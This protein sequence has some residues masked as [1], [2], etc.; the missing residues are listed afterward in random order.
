LQHRNQPN[1]SLRPLNIGQHMPPVAE[2]IPL[3]VNNDH[4]P[5]LSSDNDSNDDEFDDYYTAPVVGAERAID[6]SQNTWSFDGYGT[7]L[8]EMCWSQWIDR[9][10]RLKPRFFSM[11]PNGG[12]LQHVDHLLPMV[13]PKSMTLEAQKSEEDSSPW[14]TPSEREFTDI[15]VENGETQQA[16]PPD[17]ILGLKDMLDEAGLAE[18]TPESQN[19]F[20]CGKT[21]NEEFF[22]VNPEKDA[23]EIANTDNTLSLDV[24]S[25][26]HVTQDLKFREAMHLHLLPLLGSRAPFWKTNHVTVEVLCPPTEAGVRSKRTKT[27]TL[28][29]IPHTHFG[30][31]SAGSIL[32]NVYV[33]FPR[34]IQKHPCGKFMLNMVPR[35]VQEVWQSNAIIPAAREVFKEDFP[36]TTEYIPW[37]IDHMKLR[38]GETRGIKTLAIS[39][40]C[41][42]RLQL[43]LWWRV[44]HN[45]DLLSRFGSYF[46][47][48]DARGIK[49]LSKQYPIHTDPHHILQMMLPFLDLEH[50]LNREHGE[51]IL[52]M[53][54]SYH[55]P[56]NREPLVGL[57]KLAEVA[58]SYAAMG[59]NK[60]TTHH[61]CILAMYGGRQA[62]MQKTRKQHT[63]L[64]A[65]S[66]YN[67][68][69]ELVCVG[70]RLE[71]LCKD[72]DASKAG[73]KYM[74]A[75]QAW[76]DLFLQAIHESFGT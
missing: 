76:K 10:W 61:T 15:L 24:D 7:L 60:G 27:F 4:H 59:A 6:A 54:I 73:V 37:S 39:P 62:P 28:N 42:T 23:V 33:F 41:L 3:Q 18:N 34:M 30:Q 16:P 75:C 57:W 72:A 53:G 50:M 48:V 22:G 64:L 13:T 74:D 21:G 71:Y 40:E 68:V 29:Q 52:D 56:E 20:V 12:P 70:G 36:G 1:S 49:L 32:F 45:P 69:F 11:F 14:N 2:P 66:T 63:Q 25:W 47:V 9:G 17:V 67:L 44:Q 19:V 8:L 58:N 31:L 35:L 55:P 26:M 51:L 65:R 5:S 46:F 43:V 38:N